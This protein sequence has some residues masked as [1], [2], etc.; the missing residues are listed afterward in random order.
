LAGTLSLAAPH[1]APQYGSFAEEFQLLQFTHEFD[2]ALPVAL[3]GWGGR[4]G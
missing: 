4:S 2:E 3:Q 1:H